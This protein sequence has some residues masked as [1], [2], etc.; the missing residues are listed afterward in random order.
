MKAM[1]E[2]AGSGARGYG[3]SNNTTYVIGD[4]GYRTS[5]EMPHVNLIATLYIA[6][7]AKAGR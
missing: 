3:T 4:R 2:G 1:S 7:L 6:A 5:L